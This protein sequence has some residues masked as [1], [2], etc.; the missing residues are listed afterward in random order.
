[1]DL[2]S[3]VKDFLEYLELKHKDTMKQLREGQLNDEI[4]KILEQVALEISAKYKK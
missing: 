1:M 2:E 4:T 3:L